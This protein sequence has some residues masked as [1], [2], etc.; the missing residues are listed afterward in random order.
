MTNFVSLKNNMLTVKTGIAA[1]KFDKMLSRAELKDEKGNLL[2]AVGV[3]DPHSAE[4]SIGDKMLSCHGR[5][6]GELAYMAVLPA[7]TTMADVKKQ[8]GKSLLNAKK[9]LPGIVDMIEKEV[10]AV[11][12][13]FDEEE[14]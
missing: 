4:G 5:V 12:E 1:D 8:Y 14:A 3:T 13:L 11:D 9:Y 10:A 6:D 2:Y 7:A